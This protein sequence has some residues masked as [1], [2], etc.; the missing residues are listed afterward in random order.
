L[1][2]TND[3]GLQKVSDTFEWGT[4]T[5][6]VET[7]QNSQISKYSSDQTD[8]FQNG[9]VNYSSNSME[10]PGALKGGH[11]VSWEISDNVYNEQAKSLNTENGAN[12]WH[13]K[14]TSGSGG[15]AERINENYVY[16]P[17]DYMM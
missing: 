10:T 3:N 14:T 16:T 6:T 7:A 1:P 13:I 11:G 5:Y 15:D 4:T 8:S 2:K 17:N 12:L 9:Y